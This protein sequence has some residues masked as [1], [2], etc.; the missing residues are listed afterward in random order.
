MKTIAALG[1]IL[2]LVGAAACSESS[3]AAS[4]QIGGEEHDNGGG[5][6]GGGGDDGGGGGGDTALPVEKIQEIVGGHGVVDN[7][8]LVVKLLRTDIGT[9][10]TPNDIELTPAFMLHATLHFQ[11]VGNGQVMVNGEVPMLEPE[12]NPFIAALV[13]HNLI[14]QAFHQHSPTAPQVWFVHFRGVCDA[15]TLATAVRASIA[16]TDTPLPQPAPDVPPTSALDSERLASI[17]GGKAYVLPEGVVEVTVPRMEVLV[18]GI[19]VRPE[20]GPKTVIQ[21]K[22]TAG[23][24]GGG[25]T[26]GTGGGEP[27][28]AMQAQAMVDYAV[29]GREVNPILRRLKLERNWTIGA[30]KNHETDQVPQLFFMPLTKSGDAY[31]LADEIRAGLDLL[32]RDNMPKTQ[33]DAPD[34]IVCAIDVDGDGD[35]ETDGGGGGG[36]GSGSGGGHGGH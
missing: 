25:D 6:G 34:K 30:L 33:A 28:Q 35:C 22:P 12:V 18:D 29:F 36:G 8:V 32:S 3:N 20:A 23:D 4:G 1:N 21:F 15:E 17:L 11:A 9:A 19:R 27:P 14:V 2:L 5:G 31:Q 16:V 24:T 10:R 7:G 26:G 13:Q